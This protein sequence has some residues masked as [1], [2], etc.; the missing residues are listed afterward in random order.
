MSSYSNGLS[1]SLDKPMQF[2]VPSKNYLYW[3]SVQMT[4]RSLAFA[5]LAVSLFA[6][7][8]FA[9]VTGAISGIV[10]DASGA[11]VPHANIVAT[12]ATTNFSRATVSEN[13]GEFRLL[14]LPPGQYTLTATALGFDT[15]IATGINVKINDQLRVDVALKV[16]SIKE[17]VTVEAN[18]VQV[19]TD[20]TQLGQVVGTKEI[21]SLPLNGRS[22]LD[23][24]GLQAGVA[25][26]TSGS[27]SAG[28]ASFGNSFFRKHFCEWSA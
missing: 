18:S 5:A 20:S 4:C 28:P 21:L 1:L 13:N 7:N 22:F 15:F 3:E 11:T 6:I 19:E 10:R 27:T 16:G 9:D 14:A 23:L 24:L 8:S 2:S 17:S 26:A 12:E 25:P